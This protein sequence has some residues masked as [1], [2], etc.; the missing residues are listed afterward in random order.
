MTRTV[1][2]PARFSAMAGPRSPRKRSLPSSSSSS[3]PPITDLHRHQLAKVVHSLAPQIVLEQRLTVPDAP[4]T[5]TACLADDAPPL[6]LPLS[7]LRACINEACTSAL[8]SSA[9]AL[10]GEQQQDSARLLNDVDRFQSAILAVLDQLELQYR[11]STAEQEYGNLNEVKLEGERD[12]S[13][14]P[15]QSTKIQRYMLHRTLPS[16]LDVFTSAA[17]LS[18]KDL[19][20]LAKSAPLSF[21]RCL[22]VLRV[23]WKS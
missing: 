16:G 23:E 11:R 1:T 6:L 20:A 5:L 14:P 21:S 10:D 8:L 17:V 22:Y 18:D 15:H 12:D 3:S 9:M 2:G 4:E 7:V 13:A 19:D